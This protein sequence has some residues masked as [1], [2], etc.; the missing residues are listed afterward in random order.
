MADIIKI[1]ETNFTIEMCIQ[2]IKNELRDNCPDHTPYMGVCQSCGRY[3]NLEVLPDI[4][5]LIEALNKLK[6]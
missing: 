4:E 3:D 6:L 1:Q 5:V 2:A